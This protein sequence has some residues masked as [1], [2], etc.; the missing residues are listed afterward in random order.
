MGAARLAAPPRVA[1][2]SSHA[3]LGGS[4][5][6][7][8]RLIAGLGPGWTDAIVSLADG[9]WLDRARGLGV[10]V[11]LVPTG[12]CGGLLTGALGLRRVLARRRPDVVHANGVKAALVAVLA[13]PGLGLPVV[14]VKHDFSWDGRLAGLIAARCRVVVAVSE[15]VAATFGLHLRQKVRVVPNGIPAADMEADR[16]A[17]RKAAEVLAGAAPD[18]PVLTMVGR[19][20]EV[21]AP[22]ELVECLP[23]LLARRPGL[24]VLLVGE[25]NRHDPGYAARL[26]ARVAE[27]G[28]GEA[29]T[30]A[31][32]REDAV[33]LLAGSDLAV[34]TTRPDARGM[35]TEG[36]G[37]VAAE[38]MAVG[39]PVVGYADGALPEV[40]GD[41][42]VLVAPGDREALAAV[43]ARLL[44]DAA[45]HGRLAERGR[46]RA[47]ERYRL[48]DMIAAMRHEY[49]RS[50]RR[51][52]GPW[53]RALRVLRSR[54]SVILGFH[55]VAPRDP[56]VDP[57]NHT[58]DPDRFRV[59]VGRLL[60]A[61]F[62]FVTVAELARRAG[63]GRPPAGLAVLSFDD[64]MDNNHSVLLPILRELGVPATVYVIT[65]LI[66]RPN[67]WMGARSGARMMTEDELRELAAGGVEIGAHTVTHPDMSQL[68]RDA[69]LDEMVRSKQALEAL[70]GAPVETFAYPYC[71]YGPEAVDAARAAGFT[72]AVTCLGNGSW[73]PYET[74]RSMMTGRDGPVAVALKVL[75][76]YDP[77]FNSLPG[78]ALRAS[79]RRIRRR[80]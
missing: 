64:G 23:E 57:E 55:G 19:L 4:E 16:A 47:R 63:G 77:L 36:F 39:T 5:L 51:A 11:E 41:G 3:A 34:I 1:F 14:W 49:L 54:R 22:L 72:A 66:G 61:G 79:T 59:E 44:D 6:Y 21:K 71:R 13:T 29:V 42:G 2:V 67:P 65:G 60:C 76:L 31:G 27:L 56:A 20:D 33:S 75:E 80:G 40:V 78:R 25:E 28:V 62:E 70:L 52:R 46:A 73:A 32:R 24:R 9:P 53:A 35:G 43:I 10:E 26:R 37:L 38:A 15:A 8:E 58:M 17:G 48:D 45:E 74:K 50:A 30:L 12:A 18:A 7:L 68:G 69:C